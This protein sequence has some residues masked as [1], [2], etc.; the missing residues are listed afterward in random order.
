MAQRDEAYHQGTV[1]PFL[2]GPFVEAYLRVNNFSHSAKKD[3]AA[4]V[5]PLL[6]H[7]RKDGCIGSIAEI[8]DGDEPYQPKGAFAQAW[9]IA[10]LLSANHLIND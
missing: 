7:L 4:F 2:I 3:C 6:K 5:R 10:Q 9:S 1:W 8:F